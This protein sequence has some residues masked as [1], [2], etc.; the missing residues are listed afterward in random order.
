MMTQQPVTDVPLPAGTTC[1]DGWQHDE[2]RT[3]RI[4]SGVDRRIPGVGIIGTSAVQFTDGSIDTDRD[5]GEGPRI[6]LN[7]GGDSVTA[8]Q[9]R[10]AAQSILAAV[11][12]TELW[13]APES[14]RTAALALDTA[15]N[16]V[17]LVRHDLNATLREASTMPLFAVSDLVAALGHLRQAAVLID[18]CADQ[19]EAT[20]AEAGR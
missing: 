4:L 2:D 18:R 17:D 12:E 3:Y 10:K 14:A 6:W 16:V 9:A 1:C 19:L 7:L 8:A 5:G 20:D 13:T 15:V 11:Q